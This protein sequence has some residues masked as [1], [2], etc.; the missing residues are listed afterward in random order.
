MKRKGRQVNVLGLF[1]YMRFLYQLYRIDQAGSDPQGISDLIEG[2]Q[3]RK[4][5]EL[6]SLIGREM[7]ESILVSVCV[8]LREANKSHKEMEFLRKEFKIFMEW[9]ETSSQVKGK[10]IDNPKP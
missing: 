9:L 8:E 4:E 3:L 2:F 6:K 7:P 1:R 5:A 10:G